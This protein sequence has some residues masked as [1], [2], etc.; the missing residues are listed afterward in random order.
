[1][2]IVALSRTFLTDGERHFKKHVVLVHGFVNEGPFLHNIHP[3]RSQQN[4]A[5]GLSKMSLTMLRKKGE[6]LSERLLQFGP[7]ARLN[8]RLHPQAA[9]DNRRP[10]GLRSRLWRSS[11]FTFGTQTRLASLL[12]SEFV[13]RR[14]VGRTWRRRGRRDGAAADGVENDLVGNLAV[15]GRLLLEFQGR[16]VERGAGSRVWTW[17]RIRNCLQVAAGRG[18]R[19]GWSD[20]GRRNAKISSR[21]KRRRRV[22]WRCYWSVGKIN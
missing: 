21:Q 15:N 4:S 2:P 1:M 3:G 6:S 17:G 10:S 16:N 9:L 20:A 14:A 12:R 22:V 13:C 18:G 7:F 8:W 19:C 11:S 5:S